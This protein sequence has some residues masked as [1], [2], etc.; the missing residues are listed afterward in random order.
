MYCVF[1]GKPDVI[2][3]SRCGRWVCP[4]HQQSWRSHIVCVGCSRRLA[5]ISF[6]QIAVA[7][8]ALAM[9]GFTV[10]WAFTH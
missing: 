9:I 8:L 1:C 10:V 7:A 3:C 4:R 2:A 5:R 6:M